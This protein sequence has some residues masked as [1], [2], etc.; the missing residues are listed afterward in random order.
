MGRVL[1]TRP[2]SQA[3][4]PTRW[5]DCATDPVASV[6]ALEK[7]RLE[8]AARDDALPRA[9]TCQLNRANSF[10]GI[11]VRMSLRESCMR[12]TCTCSLS[13]GRRPA[14]QRA[15]SDPT[16]APATKAQTEGSGE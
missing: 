5:L 6:Q 15:S 9:R 2:R 8:T 14:R 12:E 13:G 7:R 10:I 3:L 16:V 11:S 4:P 1:Q